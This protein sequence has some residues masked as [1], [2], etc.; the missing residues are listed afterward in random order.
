MS[1]TFV[2]GE[3]STTLSGGASIPV[4]PPLAAATGNAF[5]ANPV[6]PNGT[7]AFQTSLILGTLVHGSQTTQVGTD[8]PSTVDHRLSEDGFFIAFHLDSQFNLVAGTGTTPH[9]YGTLSWK[10][11][12][13][14]HPPV[15]SGANATSS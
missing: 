1:G 11:I 9:G 2:D 7:Y 13:P 10:A 8:P 15:R 5:L 3:V 4:L 6:V 14:V 12:T